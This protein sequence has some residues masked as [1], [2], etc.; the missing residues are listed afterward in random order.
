LKYLKYAR[1][2]EKPTMSEPARLLIKSYWLISRKIRVNRKGE[3]TMA[4]METLL[5]LSESHAKL[6]LQSVIEVPDALI[7]IMLVEES[8]LLVTRSSVLGFKLMGHKRNIDTYGEAPY[9][10]FYKH[11]MRFCEVHRGSVEE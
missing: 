11:V 2:I 1:E 6:R 4:T 7:A 9:W 10:E 5:Q 3:I 8:M